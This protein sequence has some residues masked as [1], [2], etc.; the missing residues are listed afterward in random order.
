MFQGSHGIMFPRFTLISR[1][2]I[3]GP[4]SERSCRTRTFYEFNLE[5]HAGQRRFGFHGNSAGN[6]GLGHREAKNSPRR[7]EFG[8]SC[9][10]LGKHSHRTVTFLLLNL[11]GVS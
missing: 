2:I 8:N 4:G 6:L 1:R 3:P 7:L 5:H 10:S 9:G 11:L